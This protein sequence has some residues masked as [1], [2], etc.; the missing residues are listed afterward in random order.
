MA[1]QTPD[2]EAAQEAAAEEQD[3][4]EPVQQKA[5]DIPGEGQPDEDVKFDQSQDPPDDEAT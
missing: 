4:D 2:Q 5:A 3:T 1:E